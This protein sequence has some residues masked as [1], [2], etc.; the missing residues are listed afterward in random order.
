MVYNLLKQK[1]RVV[2]YDKNQEAV[3]RLCKHGAQRAA[4][5]A[6]VAAT[7]GKGTA[8]DTITTI[9]TLQQWTAPSPI[10]SFCPPTVSPACR[11]SNCR[12]NF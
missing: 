1:Y 2:L 11:G 6:E 3:E 5:P 8:Q 9:Y 7:P 4:S 10:S 12:H